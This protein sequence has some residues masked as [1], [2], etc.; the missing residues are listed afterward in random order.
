MYFHQVKSYL[1]Q[2][3]VSFSCSYKRG[4]GLSSPIGSLKQNTLA[5]SVADCERV[6]THLGI[7]S[8][9][10]VYG[11]SNGAT[12]GLAYAASHPAV[13]GSVVLRGLWLIRTQDV[14]YDY[15]SMTGKPSHYPQAWDRFAGFVGCGRHDK[16]KCKGLT[17]VERYRDALNGPPHTA[18]RAAD[19]WLRY[20]ALGSTVRVA[21]ESESKSEPE[22]KPLTPALATARLGV[23]LYLSQAAD[24]V[25]EIGG[26]RLLATA[27]TRLR[28]TPIR[29]VTGEYDM[30]CPPAMA[31]EVAVGMKAYSMLSI[32]EEKED[33]LNAEGMQM[34]TAVVVPGAAHAAGDANMTAVIRKAIEEAGAFHRGGW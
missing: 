22:A 5:D 33:S 19:E 17:L 27:S 32:G 6:R 13:V 25:S 1:Q 14:H 10:G 11:G 9:A 3:P 4:W 12:L 18:M 20:D 30:L 23:H 28:N 7:R 24:Q 2:T 21:A 26:G 16:N 31:Y 29:L 15:V 8:W 34:H